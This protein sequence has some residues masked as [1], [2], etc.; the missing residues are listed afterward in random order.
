M[1]EKYAERARGENEGGVV[2][3]PYL[4]YM[5]GCAPYHLTLWRFN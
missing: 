2:C 5:C 3:V 4:R 1:I